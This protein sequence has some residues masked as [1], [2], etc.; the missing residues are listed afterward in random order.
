MSPGMYHSPHGRL[1]P[2]LL[3]EFPSFS[4][5]KCQSNDEDDQQDE[6]HS[7]ANAEDEDHV[8]SAHSPVILEIPLSL[9]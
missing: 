7:Q 1:P 9:A 3:P 6:G 5:V 2:R 8:I 4:Q